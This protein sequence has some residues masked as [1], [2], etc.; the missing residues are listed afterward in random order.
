MF[1]TSK[2]VARDH[3]QDVNDRSGE[4]FFNGSVK[5]PKLREAIARIGPPN[6]LVAY[7]CLAFA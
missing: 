3:Q 1:M 2:V 7:A 4:S 5:L 6:I